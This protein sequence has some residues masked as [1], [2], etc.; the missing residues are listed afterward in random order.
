M[1]YGVHLMCP[2]KQTRQMQK[3]DI[4]KSWSCLTT[5]NGLSMDTFFKSLY[6]ATQGK[7]EINTVQIL[8]KV[9]NTIN[10]FKKNIVQFTSAS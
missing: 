6:K 8:T 9:S 5:R 1:L 10:N 2:T 4:Q 3:R 7:E